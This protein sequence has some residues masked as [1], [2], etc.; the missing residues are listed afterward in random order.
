MIA[1]LSTIAIDCLHADGFNPLN[2]SGSLVVEGLRDG[3]VLRLDDGFAVVD[4][5]DQAI[6]IAVHPER[7]RRGIGREL[8]RKAL[9]QRPDYGVWSFGTL[10]AAA[11]LAKSAGLVPT[12]EL[13]QLGRPLTAA[14]DIAP[15]AGIRGFAEDDAPAV[16]EVNRLAFAHHPEQGRLDLDDFHGIARQ[17]WFDP[18]GLLV[19]DTGRITGFHWTKRHDETTGE[20]YVLA[21]HPEAEGRG[22]G[23]TLLEQGFAHLYRV[24][25]TRVILY[26][27]ADQTR[28]VNLYRAAGFETE[29][30]DTLYRQERP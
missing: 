30:V 8:L 26:V 18:A 23:R 25:C 1:N 17:R 7:R 28:V 20:V 16:V 11:A 24:G 3:Q 13:L 21:V 29:N 12:R 4:D 14:D 9:E 22:L 19:A 27:E 15:V 5:H 2:D 6:L 10:Q